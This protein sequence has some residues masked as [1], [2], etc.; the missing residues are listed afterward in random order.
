MNKQNAYNIAAALETKMG[1]HINVCTNNELWQ[2]FRS[3]GIGY[4]IVRD[5]DIAP[6]AVAK[7][8][9]DMFKRPPPPPKRKKANDD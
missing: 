6:G 8:I 1:E 5:T 7:Q 9:Y 3:D 4:A 2:W